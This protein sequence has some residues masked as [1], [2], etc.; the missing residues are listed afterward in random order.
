M[1]YTDVA[2]VR[3]ASGFSASAKV[4]DAYITTKIT[5]ADALIDSKVGERYQLPFSSTPNL[6]AWL[7]LEIAVAVLFIDQYGE[8]AEDK[9]KGWKKR[10]DFL[11]KIL[12]EIRTGKTKLFDATTGAE[13]SRSDAN[14][15]SSHPSEAT[16]AA[17]AEDSTAAKLAMND[18]F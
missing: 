2:T 7:A 9:D 5:G 14:L 18:K 4:S 6:V 16:S 12:E 15:P 13:L 11:M 8:E 10:L 1:A 17:D 3:A